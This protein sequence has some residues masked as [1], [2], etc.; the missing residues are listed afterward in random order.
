MKVPR[1][2]CKEETG[3]IRKGTS[4]RAQPKQCPFFG[5]SKYTISPAPITHMVRSRRRRG[6][7]NRDK[8]PPPVPCYVILSTH[9]IGKGKEEVR[10]TFL[11]WG[12]LLANTQEGKEQ[13]RLWAL[14][15]WQNVRPGK[16]NKGK[17]KGRCMTMSSLLLPRN[18]ISIF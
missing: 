12:R 5:S 3:H 7:A 4:R 17:G 13:E 10:T 11:C 6:V 8:S 18:N 14:S 2:Q 9:K 1:S 15:C 16:K